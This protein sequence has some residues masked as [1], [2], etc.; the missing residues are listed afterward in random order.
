MIKMSNPSA[1][2]LRL[3]VIDRI[4]AVLEAITAGA[5]YWYTPGQ[6]EK[7]FVH[8]TEAKDFP[9]Y[10]VS[11][12][13]GGTMELAGIPYNYDE[14]FFVSIKGI[15]QD[16]EDTVTKLNRAL[17]DV[18]AAIQADNISTAAGSLGLLAVDCRFEAPPDTDDGYLSLEGFGF[19]DQRLKITVS[20]T[21]AEL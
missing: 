9:C 6:V 1:N 19:F 4:V 18:R 13:S 12:A 5:S 14:T 8:W 21:F 16:T 3:Q 10:S 2:P 17:R 7:R 15:V 20:G 11:D